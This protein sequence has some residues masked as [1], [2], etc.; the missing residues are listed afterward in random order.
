MTKPKVE[1]LSQV[2][3]VD[4]ALWDVPTPDRRHGYRPDQV[5]PAFKA[6]ASAG[7]AEASGA[8]YNRLMDALG[9]NHSGTPYPAM[10]PGVRLLAEF[11][12][13]LT[14]WSLSAALSVLTDCY[15][16]TREEPEFRTADGRVHNPEKE[17]AR[18]VRALLPL[19]RS[20]ACGE[21]PA[22]GRASEELIGAL[23]D[24]AGGHAVAPS[25]LDLLDDAVAQRRSRWEVLGCT[26]EVVRWPETDK[27][28][29]SLRVESA[30]ATGELILWTSGEADMTFAELPVQEIVT[31][32]YELTGW[33]GL[34]GCLDDFEGHLGLGGGFNVT[35]TRYG[36]IYYGPE[37]GGG[38]AGVSGSARAGWINQSATPSACQTDQFI[39]GAG[40]TVS[41]YLPVVGGIAGPSVGETWG[42]EGG[43]NANDFA[44]EVGVG[45][46]AGH[47]VGVNQGY[48]FRAPFNAP[49]W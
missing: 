38:I 42:N 22:V 19:V 12:P 37:V 45:F 35:I 32:H 21:D 16:W 47:N 27:P 8:A 15:L 28:A 14:G 24:H 10:V 1:F 48:N 26:V 29:A 6:L 41:G 18:H 20:F 36:Q 44:T 2:R 46:G 40:L 7:T 39:H 34:D 49:G 17:I 4:W 33:D 5:P 3:A 31:E 13:T 9:H 30:S 43:T 25:C 23:L 11:V